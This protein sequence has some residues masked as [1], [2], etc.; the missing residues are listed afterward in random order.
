MSAKLDSHETSV[1]LSQFRSSWEQAGT[2]KSTRD[3][4]TF[5]FLSMYLGLQPAQNS[6]DILFRNWGDEVVTSD[7]LLLLVQTLDSQLFGGFLGTWFTSNTGSS[8]RAE[9]VDS[10]TLHQG[11]YAR[12]EFTGFRGVVQSYAVVIR[13]SNTMV[14][15]NHGLV[16]V[17]GKQC[18]GKICLR[19]IVVHE[20]MHVLEYIC[21]TYLSPDKLEVCHDFNNDDRNELFM[22]IMRYFCYLNTPTVH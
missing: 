11:V 4:S 10:S 6:N 19:L 1:L 21:R 9:Y 22:S 13:V 12:T 5:R 18:S 3:H 14:S 8:L 15:K 17:G 2:T 20:L 7:Q 16:F